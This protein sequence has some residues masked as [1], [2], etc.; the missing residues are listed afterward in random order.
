LYTI[1][2]KSS[3]YLDFSS[4]ILL[5]YKRVMTFDQVILSILLCILI[6]GFISLS[7]IFISMTV[8][9][10]K[11]MT[12]SVNNALTNKLHCGKIWCTSKAVELDLPDKIP[13]TYNHCFARY[14]ADLI[15]R[16]ETPSNYKGTKVI[17]PKD[18]NIILEL[19]EDN[20]DLM[21]GMVLLDK[22]NNIWIAYR[23]TSDINDWKDDFTYNQSGLPGQNKP[24]YQQKADFLRSKYSVKD[25]PSPRV[26]TGFINVYMQFREKLI[27]VLNKT[28]HKNITITGHSLGGAITAITAAD[29]YNQGYKPVSYKFASPRVGDKAFSDLV[30][31]DENSRLYHIYN[32]SDIVP[33]LP[34][35]VSPNLKETNRPYFY[36]NCGEN[37]TF[38]NNWLSAVNNHVMSVHIHYLESQIKQGK[39]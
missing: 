34:F 26:H 27:D 8:I 3:R 20:I 23:G 11:N 18:T 5:E 32:T 7:V 4:F 39:C 31:R 13:I 24:I 30:D 29:L 6:I 2:E 10:F 12:D 38:T 1:I 21:F 33:T 37:H 9:Y 25:T 19:Y 28:N 22:N 35:A 16:I 17:A 14:C 15:V 36:E